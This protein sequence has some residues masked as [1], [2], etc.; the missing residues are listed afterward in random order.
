E[1]D[2][3][4]GAVEYAT[5][6][7]YRDTVAAL[8][9]RFA[10]LLDAVTADPDAPFQRAD[11]LGPAERDRLLELGGAP[12]E[13]PAG[14]LAGLFAEQARRTP[15]AVAVVHGDA[16]LT[17]AGLDARADRLAAALTGRG[18][19]RE[20][21]VAVLLERSPELV[22]ALLAVLKAGGAYVP[23][24]PRYPTAR[25]E[26]ILRGS[27]ATTVLTPEVLAELEAAEPEA[28]APETPAPAVPAGVG[29]PEQ[30][31]YVMYTSGSTGTPKGVG[32]T[33]RDVVELALDPVWRGGAHER[34]LLHA[35][36]AFD[37]STYE[38]WVPLLSGGCVVVTPPGEF[39]PAVLHEVITRQRVTALVLPYSLLS[40][41]VDERPETFA[42]VREL[43]TAGEAV[44]PGAVAQV[45]RAC[46]GVT[47]VNAYGPTETTVYSTHH[48]VTTTPDPARPVPIGGPTRGTCLRVLDRGLRLAPPGVVGELHIAGSGLARGYVGAPGRTAERFVADPFGAPGSRMYRTGDLVRRL[49][50]GELEFVGRADGQV[51]LRGF[52]IELGEVETALERLPEVA[53]ATVVVREDRPGHPCLVAYLVPAPGAVVDPGALAEPLRGQVPEYAVPSAFVVLDALPLT[54]NG[55]LDRAALPAP[56]LPVRGAG[57]M[58]RTPHEQLLCELF[59]GV[60]GRERVHVDEG[61]FELGGHSLLAARLVAMVRDVLGVPLGLRTLFESPTPAALAAHLDV[62]DPDNALDVLLPLRAAGAGAPLFCVHPGG[63]ISWC[64]SGLLSHLPADQPVYALQ[65]RGLG[66]VEPLPSSYEEMARDYADQIRKIQP[67]GPYRLLGWSAGGL[68]AHA[69]ACELQEA[70][71]RT[72]LLA[73]LDA[74]PVVDVEFFERSPVPSERDVLVGIL[75]CAPDEVDEGPMSRD[76]VVRVLRERGSALAGLDER[77]VAAVVEIMINNGRLAL[78]HRPGRFEGDLLLFNSTVDRGGDTATPDHW[79]PYVTGRVHSHDI[80]ARHDR[81]TQPGSLA[82][83]GPVVAAALDAV[84][85]GRAVGDGGPGGTTG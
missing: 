48:R 52:R 3:L 17:Y 81:M 47:V 33:H 46:P 11:L 16:E 80:G 59:A 62:G 14:D 27:G 54:P 5:D 55:K 35:P 69:V 41:L 45:L 77:Q 36:V 71:E 8:L 19:G 49:P 38:L 57:L 25:V 51:K 39:D 21:R 29:H 30:L 26:L 76:D 58:P 7:F 84:A 32:V 64:Y 53:R 43:I 85:G 44:A 28:T 22:V 13:P 12:V 75:D 79:R 31:A 4:F 66:R 37:L 60:L 42:H 67:S 6:L 68:I 63:G 1:P 24:D 23:L 9:D 34:V 2:G 82:Q 15:D 10:R 56:E 61:F 78:E 72:E 74:Y 20:T 70:G 83:I 40:L 65:A 50:G 18:V 73:I